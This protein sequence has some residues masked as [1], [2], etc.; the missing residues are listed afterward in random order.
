MIHSLFYIGL[1][2]IC[3]CTITFF[4]HY[5]HICLLLNSPKKK[6]YQDNFHLEI[7][8]VCFLIAISLAICGAFL[9]SELGKEIIRAIKS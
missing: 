1:T 6:E 9:S 7:W 8:F 5:I 2:G 3:L 4:V